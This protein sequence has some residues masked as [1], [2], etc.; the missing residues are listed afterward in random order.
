MHGAP[1][2]WRPPRSA[3]VAEGP[4]RRRRGQRTEA[5][6]ASVRAYP[7]LLAS[8]IHAPADGPLDAAAR[9]ARAEPH[10]WLS[11][12][13]RAGARAPIRRLR[14]AAALVDRGSRRLLVI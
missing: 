10:R 7:R 13:A 2:G 5:R 6:R 3:R 4:A 11:R 9:R 14:R 1:R 8:S 12:L